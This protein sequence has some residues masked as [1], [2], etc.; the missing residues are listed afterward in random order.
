MTESKP[1]EWLDAKYIEPKDSRLESILR[2]RLDYQ[3]ESTFSARKVLASKLSNEY[4]EPLTRNGGRPEFFRGVFGNDL[5]RNV[6]S[7]YNKPEA[8]GRYSPA[9]YALFVYTPT[10]P[11]YEKDVKSYNETVGKNWKA[12]SDLE[13]HNGGDETLGVVPTTASPQLD[14][15]TLTLSQATRLAFGSPSG[16]SQ[17]GIA[18]PDVVEFEFP[19]PGTPDAPKPRFNLIARPEGTPGDPISSG[20]I[21]ATLN[22]LIEETVIYVCGLHPDLLVD[23]RNVVQVRHGIPIYMNFSTLAYQTRIDR[24]NHTM[25]KMGED[26]LV[27][28]SLEA[29]SGWDFFKYGGIAP[30]GFMCVAIYDDSNKQGNYTLLSSPIPMSE[31]TVNALESV[32]LDGDLVYE[33]NDRFDELVRFRP[34]TLDVF[35]KEKEATARAERNRSG[36]SDTP[37]NPEGSVEFFVFEGDLVNP[38]ARKEISIDNVVP[39]ALNVLSRRKETI[40]H[41]LTDFIPPIL[42]TD[43]TNGDME[44]I[45]ADLAWAR[46]DNG[47]WIVYK[48]DGDY[49]R[50]LFNGIVSPITALIEHVV[51]DVAE[52]VRLSIA[53]QVATRAE[54]KYHYIDYKG[55]DESDRIDW[56]RFLFGHPMGELKPVEETPAPPSYLVGLSNSQENTNHEGRNDGGNETGERNQIYWINHIAKLLYDNP[57]ANVLSIPYETRLW[58]LDVQSILWI[59]SEREDEIHSR[60]ELDAKDPSLTARKDLLISTLRGVSNAASPW[61]GVTISGKDA[62]SR[63]REFTYVVTRKGFPLDLSHLLGT[64][65]VA[66]IGNN[67]SPLVLQPEDYDQ[68]SNDDRLVNRQ[69]DFHSESDDGSVEDVLSPALVR[70]SE[71]TPGER[72]TEYELRGKGV[73]VKVVSRAEPIMEILEALVKLVEDTSEYRP[74]DPLESFFVKFTILGTELNVDVRSILKAHSGKDIVLHDG[75]RGFEEDNNVNRSIALISALELPSKFPSKLTGIVISAKENGRVYEYVLMESNSIFLH[76]EKV[77]LF[78]SKFNT[79]NKT[80]LFPSKE[81]PEQPS[82]AYPDAKSIREEVKASPGDW[83]TIISLLLE[84]D[85]THY[86]TLDGRKLHRDETVW[87]KDGELYSLYENAQSTIQ[88]ISDV[89]NAQR[90]LGDDY[91]IC[92]PYTQSVGNLSKAGR[93]IFPLTPALVER[94]LKSDFD[95]LMVDAVMDFDQQKK[96]L[97]SITQ[98]QNAVD[99]NTVDDESITNAACLLAYTEEKFDEMFLI[100]KGI[101]A[102]EIEAFSTQQKEYRNAALASWEDD[103]LSFDSRQPPETREVY[104]IKEK[105]YPIRNIYL[106]NTLFNGVELEDTPPVFEGDSLPTE[107]VVEENASSSDENSEADDDPENDVASISDHDNESVADDVAAPVEPGDSDDESTKPS[108]RYLEAGYSAD[109]DEYKAGDVLVALHA[110][111]TRLGEFEFLRNGI[112]WCKLGNKKKRFF[113]SAENSIDTLVACSALVKNPRFIIEGGIFGILCVPYEDA[114]KNVVTLQLPMTHFEMKE[115]KGL[116]FSARMRYAGRDF[117]DQQAIVNEI[118]QFLLDPKARPR[119]KNIACLYI[120]P[121]PS[122]RNGFRAVGLNTKLI[123]DAFVAA[124]SHFVEFAQDGL[125]NLT[126]MVKGS[127]FLISRGADKKISL[128]SLRNIELY[129]LLD[130]YSLSESIKSPVHIRDVEESEDATSDA[131]ATGIDDP[132]NSTNPVDTLGHVERT[133]ETALQKALDI[134]SPSAKKPATPPLDAGSPVEEYEITLFDRLLEWKGEEKLKDDEGNEI[135]PSGVVWCEK[136]PW[137]TKYYSWTE[138]NEKILRGIQVLY[139]DSTKLTTEHPGLIFMPRVDSAKVYTMPLLPKDII[140]ILE[141][142]AY[143]EEITNASDAYYKQFDIANA[144]KEYKA[145]DRTTKEKN[146]DPRLSSIYFHARSKKSGNPG[147]SIAG[148]ELGKSAD[149]VLVVTRDQC[150]NLAI[151]MWEN[152]YIENLDEAFVAIKFNAEALRPVVYPLRCALLRD[153]LLKTSKVGVTTD[154]YVPRQKGH[155]LGREIFIPKPSLVEWNRVPG[156]FC[157]PTSDSFN[158][159]HATAATYNFLTSISPDTGARHTVPR[160]PPVVE[161]TFGHVPNTGIPFH[162]GRTGD[163]REQRW[164]ISRKIPP[165]PEIFTR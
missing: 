106:Y 90:S 5:G 36:E 137:Y 136:A 17:T 49:T 121:D 56:L 59:D 66:T 119:D 80:P 51:H 89:I 77:M 164:T 37:T 33:V 100:L 53:V 93:F 98:F 146:S 58:K 24:K 31:E 116:G 79:P 25:K 113:S 67:R 3:D 158:L 127:L 103:T 12:S 74:E 23:P 107:G 108:N 152:N 118:E 18:P 139:N 109:E 163:A 42:I 11:L 8:Q 124:R 147:L 34:L 142:T 101:P 60:K 125:A 4:S 156:L 165:Y 63:V 54:Y 32:K 71:R 161:P 35:N 65:F 159:F 117:T 97:E 115:L 88:S 43:S 157:S 2:Q 144:I 7:A 19:T 110:K 83:S 132:I 140:R 102:R 145:A 131:N 155:A 129:K 150:R 38:P 114:V 87:I 61:V 9:Y 133:N 105:R 82:V 86:T 70:I 69:E 72:I 62:F 75:S 120:S 95:V 148:I 27:L 85:R 149:K 126:D 91:V 45:F 104:L 28:K 138:N 111:K 55:D 141:K 41:H 162:K 20:D 21:R 26:F 48:R 10:S 29:V 134:I 154:K 84:G 122:A 128:T 44:V 81:L 153:V 14:N 92:I 64:E 15:I 30:K 52:D 78:L 68:A 50:F 151:E 99:Q 130:K 47:S 160:K 16:N 22:N 6:A 57:N 13:G 94:L 46:Y 96:V 143:T 76:N 112:V 135:D 73:K 40:W 1:L 123:S 39:T